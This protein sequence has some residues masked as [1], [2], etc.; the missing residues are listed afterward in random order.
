[1]AAARQINTMYKKRSA[2]VSRSR[3][4]RSG[5][6][7]KRIMYIYMCDDGDNDDG[8]DY[9]TGVCF[10]H[11]CAQN[12]EHVNTACVCVWGDVGLLNDRR[13]TANDTRSGVYYAKRVSQIARATFKTGEEPVV[14]FLRKTSAL[15]PCH[16]RISDNTR[17]YVEKPA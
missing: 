8:D 5:T 11:I 7:R 3:R 14:I 2:L 10:V 1:M 12:C 15:S 4:T 9:A 6:H 13:Q 16:R 17:A